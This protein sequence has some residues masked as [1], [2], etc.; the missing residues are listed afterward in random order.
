[1]VAAVS[2]VVAAA[3]VVVAAGERRTHFTKNGLI[4]FVLMFQRTE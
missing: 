1:V 4:L 3:A 2:L